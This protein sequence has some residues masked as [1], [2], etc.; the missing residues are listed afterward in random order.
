MI[1][2]MFENGTLDLE[3]FVELAQTFLD[4]DAV[5]GLFVLGATGE[6]THF[7]YEERKNLFRS[8]TQVRKKGKIIMV[9]AGGLPKEETIAL[10]EFAAKEGLDGVFIPVPSCDDK[11]NAGYFFS[12][13]EEI[14][15]TGLPFMVYWPRGS[16]KPCLALIERLIK[17][18]AFVGIK[19]SS[20]DMEL[21]MRICGS[22][23]KILSIFQGVET[24]HLA[25]LAC[26]SA[27]II[28]GGLN[29]YPGLL[30]QIT[31]A[32]N[33]HNYE[34]ARNLQL[35]VIDFWDILSANNNFRWLCKKIWKE[36]GIIR[37]DY[38]K[39]G[40]KNTNDS[41]EIAKVKEMVCL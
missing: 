30:A 38:C 25:S 18:P 15:R 5:N 7:N 28:G 3:G 26:G 24:L 23:G 17:I 33:N 12:Y 37:G 14:G 34:T 41:A 13:F 11:N 9:N 35:K 20:R 16:K 29:L 27:G 2:P 21:F 36:R 39:E 40:K 22:F 1:T 6:Y 31:N 19:D 32:F 4:A 8:L 10:T